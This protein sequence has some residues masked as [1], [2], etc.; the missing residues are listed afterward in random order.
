MF[1]LKPEV[2]PHTYLVQEISY[3][4]WATVMAQYLEEHHK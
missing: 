4:E 1:D 2:T 3:L